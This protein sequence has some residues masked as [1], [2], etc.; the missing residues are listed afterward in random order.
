[1]NLIAEAAKTRPMGRTTPPNF[2]VRLMGEDRKSKGGA[3][4]KRRP[5]RVYIVDLVRKGTV[6]APGGPI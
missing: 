1:M 5:A 6:D 4:R 2:G 3:E